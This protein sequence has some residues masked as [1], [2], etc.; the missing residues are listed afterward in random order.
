M[1]G[2]FS[3]SHS[4]KKDKNGK[5]TKEGS[6]SNLSIAASMG[7]NIEKTKTLATLGSGNITLTGKNKQIDE[8]LNRDVNNT[9]KEL[10]KVDQTKGVKLV[11]DTRLLTKDGRK[12]IKEE[13]QIS[14]KIKDTISKIVNT[15]DV[16]IT[17]FFSETKFAVKKYKGYKEVL[18]NN[19]D[20]I[21]KMNNPKTSLEYKQI[22]QNQ[23]LQALKKQGIDVAKDVKVI[24]TNEKGQGNQNVSGFITTQDDRIYSN[25][26]NQET[27]RDTQATLGHEIGGAY[28]KKKGID[29]TTNREQHNN[30]QD[31]IAQ[32]T[33]DDI[34]FISSNNNLN[35]NLD[36]K[37][38]NFKKIY[39]Q[40]TQV[41][42]VFNTIASNNAEFAGLDKELGDNLSAKDFGINNAYSFA[43]DLEGNTVFVPNIQSYPQ[44]DTTITKEGLIVGVKAVNNTATFTGMASAYTANGPGIFASGVAI[45]LTD[46][47][48]FGVDE[49]T[50]KQIYRESVIDQII[51]NNIKGQMIAGV[52]KETMKVIDKRNNKDKK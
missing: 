10:Y 33:L 1:N 7:L 46:V 15:K 6:L 2:S 45:L 29:I 52:I 12:E 14:S 17:D 47:I 26:F 51:P 4:D 27:S 25:D 40:T 36:T 41:N 49:K 21:D 50:S 28:Q 24:S 19:K 5:T 23:I 31:I 35:I 39:P 42:S 18:V 11:V 38:N 37:N 44:F 20:I 32:E 16:G 9:K 30:Y 3:I 43:L 8:R 13:I 34:K 22:Y 48:L